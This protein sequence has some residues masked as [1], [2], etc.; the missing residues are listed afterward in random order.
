MGEEIVVEEITDALLYDTSCWVRRVLSS[1]T[2]HC[3]EGVNQLP[4]TRSEYMNKA[5][6]AEKRAE[7]EIGTCVWAMI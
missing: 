7:L 5:A 6:M 3:K 4:Y 2:D 1:V